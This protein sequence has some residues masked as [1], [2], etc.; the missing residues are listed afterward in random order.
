VIAFVIFLAVAGRLAV[1]GIGPFEASVASAVADGN[2]LSVTLTVT[3]QGRSAGQTT[4]RIT[5]PADR[6]GNLGGFMLSPQIDPGETRTFTQSLT[7]LGTTVRPL[8]AE[9]SAP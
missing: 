8:L 4:C 3:N 9:C 7:Q 6:T 1:A 2:G 5:D